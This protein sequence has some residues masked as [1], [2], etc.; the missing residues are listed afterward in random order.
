MTAT[1][2]SVDTGW[3]VGSPA[4]FKATFPPSEIPISHSGDDGASR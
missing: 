4:S 3:A 2:E 1:C